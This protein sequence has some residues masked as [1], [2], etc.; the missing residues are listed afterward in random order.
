M[1]T[2]LESR[3]LSLVFEYYLHLVMSSLNLRTGI[4][5]TLPKSRDG[6]VIRRQSVLRN[7]NTSTAEQQRYPE[8]DNLW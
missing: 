4:G 7:F 1:A 8:A 2:T 5:K 6:L 3:H